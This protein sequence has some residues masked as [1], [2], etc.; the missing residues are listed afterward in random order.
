[1]FRT[2]M[3]SNERLEYDQSIANFRAMVAEEEF[4]ALWK[5]RRL[6]T[7]EEAIDLALKYGG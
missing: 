4:H 3:T 2:P 1:M 6:M 7:L 5:T